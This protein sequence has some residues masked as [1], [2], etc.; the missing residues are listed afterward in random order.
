MPK[1]KKEFALK[2]NQEANEIEIINILNTL[3]DKN[4]MVRE[5]NSFLSLAVPLGNY[6]PSKDIIN[7]LAMILK[8]V[9]VGA[10]R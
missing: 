2:Y 8:A 9:P 1:I 6:K 4:L 3:I 7:K 10:S 5:N